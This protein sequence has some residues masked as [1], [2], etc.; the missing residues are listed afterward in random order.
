MTVQKFLGCK[1]EKLELL[2]VMGI[3]TLAEIH[4]RN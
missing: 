1:K 4:L 3:E 2:W